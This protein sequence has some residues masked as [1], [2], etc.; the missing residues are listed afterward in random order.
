MP[1]EYQ[2]D[3]PVS[4]SREVIEATKQHVRDHLAAVASFD[5]DPSTYSDDVRLWVARH[6]DNPELLRVEGY[7]NAEPDAPYLRDTYD[8]LAS[9]DEQ[10]LRSAGLIDG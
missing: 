1:L 2:R 7:L 5:D 9:I 6:P 4:A 8:P 3:I 10:L